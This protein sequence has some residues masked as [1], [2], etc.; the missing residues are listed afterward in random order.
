MSEAPVAA[1]EPELA[2][3]LPEGFVE[4]FRKTMAELFAVP[5][6]LLGEPIHIPWYRR[7]RYRLGD[8]RE[9]FAGRVYKLMAGHDLPE[10]DW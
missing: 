9:A 10:S 3:L 4:E 2:P 5:P 6:E 1:E 8:A 7:L